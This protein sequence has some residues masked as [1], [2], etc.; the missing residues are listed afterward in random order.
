MSVEALPC[1]RCDSPLENVF[2]DAENQPHAGLAFTSAGHYGGTLFD[3]MDGSY[4]EISLC[5]KCLAKMRDA[6]RVLYGRKSKPVI[7]QG[8]VVGWTP[9][10]RE[11]VTWNGQDEP[12][13]EPLQIGDLDLENGDLLPEIHWNVKPE[14]LLGRRRP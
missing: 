6:G 10:H 11:L 3:P 7:Y 1:V 2:D 8:D 13:E 5:D 4:I 14:D 9:V 12:P